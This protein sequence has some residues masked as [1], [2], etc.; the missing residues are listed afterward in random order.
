VVGKSPE[1]T[2]DAK[3]FRDPFGRGWGR[4]GFDRETQL[5]EWY[6]YPEGY[7][8]WLARPRFGWKDIWRRLDLIE[9]DFQSHYHLNLARELRRKSNTARW[10]REMILGLIDE[11]TRLSRA[12]RTLGGDDDG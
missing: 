1:P 3:R 2:G 4:G 8:E 12:L 6:D 5:Y 11:D 9:K 10:L 7:T